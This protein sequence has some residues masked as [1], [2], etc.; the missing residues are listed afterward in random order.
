MPTGVDPT[1]RIVRNLFTVQR[2]GS[3]ITSETQALLDELFDQ[4]VE[5]LRRIDPTAPAAERWREYRTEQFVERVSE[6]LSDAMPG[7]ERLWRARLA[8]AGRLEAKFTEALLVSTLGDAGSRVTATPITQARV[9]SILRSRP[10]GG[11]NGSATLAEWSDALEVATR[12]RL[13]RQIRQ[14]MLNEES[15]PELVRRVRGRQAGFIRQDPETGLF[16]PKGTRGAVVKPRFVGGAW[17]STTRDAE[18]TVRTA[19]NF[20]SNQAAMET[21]QANGRLLR[22]VRFSATLDAR[23]TP[24]C[25][26]EDGNVYAMDDGDR[27]QL[28]LHWNCR[29]AWVPE[30]DWAGLGMDPP[31]EGERAARDADGN[32]IR[33]PSST[34]YEQWLR[35]QPVKVQDEILGPG[36]ARLFRGG[37]IN[38]RDLVR[39]DRT[40]V[41]LSDLAA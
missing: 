8:E 35:N 32:P 26:A 24:Q 2:I 25:M 9:R 33:V 14:G 17:Q 27:P 28:P 40:T 20:V 13:T 21:Y 39:G 31:P 11:V 1:G 22:G 38:L 41:P 19:V 4:I 37:S 10:F 34:T 18:A 6:R 12:N 16:V 15:I 23:T 5:D 36:R 29:S 3:S 30:V 7:V